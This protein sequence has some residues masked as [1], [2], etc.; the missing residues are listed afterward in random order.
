MHIIFILLFKNVPPKDTK[1]HFLNNIPQ[2]NPFPGK[3]FPLHGF[4][5]SFVAV[6]IFLSRVYIY[7]ILLFVPAHITGVYI[8]TEREKN[9]IDIILYYISLNFPLHG[10][11]VSF[12]AV[13]V[14]LSRLCIYLILL[15]VPAHITGVYI[16]RAKFF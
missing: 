10:F 1:P 3:H 11:Y 15:F 8:H 9:I 13:V 12:V 16:Y 4:Y 14:F 7:K 5:V 2:R 6:V